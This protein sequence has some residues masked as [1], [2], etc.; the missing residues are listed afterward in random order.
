MATP[1]L[2]VSLSLSGLASPRAMHASRHQSSSDAGSRGRRFSSSCEAQPAFSG[3]RRPSR[4]RHHGREDVI[5]FP[6]VVPE[7]ELVKVERQVRL[8][9]VMEA[10]RDAPLDERPEAVNRAGGPRRARTRRRCFRS[11]GYLGRTVGPDGRYELLPIPRLALAA[12]GNP[13]ASP[14]ATIPTAEAS[15]IVEAV[16]ARND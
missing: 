4:S 13:A 8:G 9:D 1:V 3:N 2:S 14:G 5:V 15:P 12:A 16:E 11:L 7:R 10:P 6:V